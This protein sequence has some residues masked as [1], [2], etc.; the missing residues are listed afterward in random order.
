MD[1]IPQRVLIY[2]TEEGTCP[3]ID[4][5]EHLRDKQAQIRIAARIDD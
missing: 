5:L 2:E 4:W 1:A 3:Y